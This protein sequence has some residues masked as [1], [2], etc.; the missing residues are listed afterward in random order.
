MLVATVQS[1]EEFCPHRSVHSVVE[2]EGAEVIQLKKTRQLHILWPSH[3][4]V[5]NLQAKLTDKWNI[6]I[7]Y[8]INLEMQGKKKNLIY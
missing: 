6:D 1:L 2:F 7:F 3:N 4:N 5:L 8:S